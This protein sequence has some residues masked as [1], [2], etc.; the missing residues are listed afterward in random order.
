VRP[1]AGQIR[2]H[3]L[4]DIKSP[5]LAKGLTSLFDL[6]AYGTPEFAAKINDKPW[7]YL[8]AQSDRMGETMRDHLK[9]H[10]MTTLLELSEGVD[11]VTAVQQLK[12]NSSNDLNAV[13]LA[14]TDT[15]IEIVSR[16]GITCFDVRAMDARDIFA[17]LSKNRRTE[18]WILHCKDYV[19]TPGVRAVLANHSFNLGC[20]YLVMLD[21]PGSYAQFFN[22]R[23]LSLGGETNTATMRDRYPEDKVIGV[24]VNTTTEKSIPLPRAT[25]CSAARRLTLAAPAALTPA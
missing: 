4:E 18:D 5:K 11:A 7:L 2:P 12:I 20:L 1:H 9:P 10:T 6:S 23:A 3:D 21:A 16:A 14:A 13:V 8:D 19:V 24:A 17:R 15:Q 22:L 25:P